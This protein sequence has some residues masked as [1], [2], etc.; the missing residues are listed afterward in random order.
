MNKYKT[1]NLIRKIPLIPFIVIWR[2][3]MF[4]F[5]PIIAI[6]TFFMTDWE[7]KWDRNYMICQLKNAISFGFWK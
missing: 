3:L 6:M 7:D 5:S 4:V 1:L 2:I